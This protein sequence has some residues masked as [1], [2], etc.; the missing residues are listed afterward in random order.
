MYGAVDMFTICAFMAWKGKNVRFSL[1][2]P[3]TPVSSNRC[4]PFSF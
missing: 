3:S 1:Y 2:R 4:R